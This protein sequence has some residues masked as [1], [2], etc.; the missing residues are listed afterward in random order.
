VALPDV[1]RQ[2]DA[3]ER[4]EH[5]AQPVDP[6]ARC[7][8]AVDALP[9]RHEAGER[10]LVGRL[11]LLAQ[12][13]ERGAPQPPQHLGIAPLA[14]GATGAQLPADELAPAFEAGQYGCEVEA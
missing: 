7:G 1:D 13:G 4:D 8:V 2:R 5:V 11:D 6:G 9:A 3:L 12:R 10:T 14:P